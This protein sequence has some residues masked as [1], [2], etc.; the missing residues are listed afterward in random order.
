VRHKAY[1]V[2]VLQRIAVALAVAAAACLGADKKP[3]EGTVSNSAVEISA[4]LYTD[5]D[6]IKKILGSDLDGYFILVDV[7]VA[8]KSGSKLAVTRDDFVLRSDK[9]GQR[10]SPFHPSQIAGSGVLVVKT[11]SGGSTSAEKGGPVWGPPMGGPPKRIGTGAPT[12]GNSP[13]GSQAS[14]SSE[15]TRGDPLLSVLKEKVLAEK[16]ITEPQSGLLYFLLEGKHK[17]KD[18]EL[19]YKGPAG[20]LSLRCKN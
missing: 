12:I 15:N 14:S 5:K 20:R 6:D 1:N 9:D 7:R 4:K 3:P 8:P 11:T 2:A 13:G 19:M 17:P 16:E 10:A 18:L